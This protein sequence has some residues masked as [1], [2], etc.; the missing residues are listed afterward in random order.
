[1]CAVARSLVISIMVVILQQRV[2]WPLWGAPESHVARRLG[3]LAGSSVRHWNR[4]SRCTG[5]GEVEAK[6]K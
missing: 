6:G 5:R 4:N 1:M 3:M 2:E